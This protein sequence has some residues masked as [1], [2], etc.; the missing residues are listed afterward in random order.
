M[1]GDY[2]GLFVVNKVR[3]SNLNDSPVRLVGQV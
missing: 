3:N 2:N 1:K